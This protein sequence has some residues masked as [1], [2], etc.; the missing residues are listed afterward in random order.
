MSS[1]ESLIPGSVMTLKLHKGINPPTMMIDDRRS[2]RQA[3]EDKS[4]V[5]WWCSSSCLN[6]S[7]RVYISNECLF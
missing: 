6:F 2:K 3:E 4:R 7:I 1:I 5:Q